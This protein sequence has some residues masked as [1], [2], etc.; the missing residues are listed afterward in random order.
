M[1]HPNRPDFSMHLV[2]FTKDTPPIC[3]TKHA[4]HVEAIVP[5]TARQRLFEI[6]EGGVVKAT[7]MP[8]TDQPAL[9]FTECTWP[10]LLA[11]S[12]RYSPYG[13]G[14]RKELIF[15]AGGGPAFYISPHL[16]E[17]Q[18]QH[19][20]VGKAAFD[21]EILAF[22]TPFAPFYAPQSY[23]DQHWS[24]RKPVDFSHEREWRIAHD[25]SFS[26]DRVSFVIVETYEDMAQAP[27]ELKDAIGRD[28]WLIMA[29]YRKIEELWP[30]HRL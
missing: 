22:L 9:C 26:L 5:L 15:A 16:L 3:A 12:Q 7:P 17:R 1:P 13:L 24:G 11:H 8:W 23:K 29:N 2:H 10:S 21:P 4:A 30:T 20:G 25:L 18:K 28:K 27:K 19:V 6:L 14:F